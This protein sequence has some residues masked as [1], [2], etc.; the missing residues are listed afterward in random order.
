M[1]KHILVPLDASADSEAMLG[2]LTPLLARP[3]SDV[4]LLHAME[5]PLSAPMDPAEA[6][7]ARAEAEGA[8][9][10]AAKRLGKLGIRCRAV[11]KPG[12]AAAA[13]V[14]AASAHPNGLIVMATHGRR[15]LKR[16][17]F[18]SV[19]ENVVRR[20]PCPVL[21]LRTPE[22]RKPFANVSFDTIL[23][24]IDG[25]V[26]ALAIVPHAAEL[27]KAFRSTVTVIHVLPEAPASGASITHAEHAI[28]TARDLFE[29]EGV[30]AT[31]VLRSGLAAEEIAEHAAAGA[32]LIA[33][34]T[35]G[36]TGLARAVLGSVAEQVLR[37][38][39]IPMLVV[40]SPA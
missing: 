25:S 35:H 15:G 34:S 39:K 4:T 37:S 31:G 12:P 30:V 23:V 22:T 17:L 40:R 9:K 10:D 11:V 1:L 32:G 6:S 28:E 14:E 33:C 24:P 36:R 3:G 20:A 27:A 5:T 2:G 8:V 13:I 18:G 38:T 7:D 16:A 21:L 26:A 29:E 19:A